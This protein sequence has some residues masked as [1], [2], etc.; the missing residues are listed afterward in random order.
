M[1]KNAG[2][3]VIAVS[4][5]A[6]LAV[7]GIVIGGSD[8]ADAKTG[9]YSRWHALMD[10]YRYD[11][12]VRELIFVK[13][14]KHAKADFVM[15]KKVIAK[16]A[17]RH[18]KPGKV[19]KVV[20]KPVIR[21]RAFVGR[22]G[23]NNDCRRDMKTPT[24]I[25]T[26]TSSFG[27][28]RNPGSKLPYTRI[29]GS[30]YLCNDNEEN[31]NKLVSTRKYPHSCGGEHMI[32]YTRSYA[33]GMILDHNKEQD[34][35]ETNGIFFHCTSGYS[36]TSG[37][38]AIKERLMRK[39]VRMCEKGTKIC[40][41]R[42]AG[43]KGKISRKAPGAK[44]A[45]HK[46]PLLVRS[47]SQ[48]YFDTSCHK[49]KLSSRTD[50]KYKKKYP[51]KIKTTDFI[52]KTSS[53]IRQKYH[54]RGKRPVS[55]KYYNE[56]KKN[57]F[58]FKY[59]RKGRVISQKGYDPLSRSQKSLWLMKWRYG[60]NGAVKHMYYRNT[61]YPSKWSRS[62]KQTYPYHYYYKTRLRKGLP[63]RSTGR[64]KV[65]KAKYITKYNGHGL[66]KSM[67][68]ITRHGKRALKARF[69]YNMKKGRVASVIKYTVNSR[70]RLQKDTK[71]VFR[72]KKYKT[73]HRR[74]SNMINDILGVYTPFGM[75]PWY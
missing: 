54:F 6:V 17:G 36:S 50:Y 72:Y 65:S 61:Y 49:W 19:S 26:L 22:D 37:C 70:G 73:G 29:N 18:S 21:T 51:S 74:Y 4:L 39:A 8:T 75:F 56:N 53:M 67:I 38:I 58:R 15:Y 34:P 16:K 14:R 33:Y 20:W 45:S 28:K 32:S 12:D 1:M 2:R 69:V 27:I 59:N 64:N 31:Y 68:H 60:K 62:V 9:R 30:H 47:A 23:I 10:R 57:T 24:G 11:K 66:V 63:S 13:Y 71:Y 25:Y 40:I 7:T 41:Y 43:H 35:T 5:T 52:A 44:S 48:Y 42:K 55:M 3:I 46:K